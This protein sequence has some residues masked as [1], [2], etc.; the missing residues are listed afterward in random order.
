MV[1]AVVAHSFAVHV[2]FVVDKMV[3]EHILYRYIGF[4]W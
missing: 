1:Q 3:T 2:G 4:P